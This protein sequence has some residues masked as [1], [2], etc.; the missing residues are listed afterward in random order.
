MQEI[1]PPLNFSTFYIYGIKDYTNLGQKRCINILLLGTTSDSFHYINTLD[2]SVCSN[3]AK[4]KK[5][6]SNY[7]RINILQYRIEELSS[8]IHKVGIH[9]YSL[10]ARALAILVQNSSLSHASK[11][12]LLDIYTSYEP[13]LF[14]T[15]VF[16]KSIE[17][18]NVYD[19]K[20]FE[21]FDLRELILNNP[22]SSFNDINNMG[23][24]H[25]NSHDSITYI[26]HTI[27]QLPFDY[28][29]LIQLLKPGESG[30]YLDT[31]N[32]NSF[33]KSNNIDPESHT[34]SEGTLELW[35]MKGSID[36]LA[37]IL[38]D[39]QFLHTTTLTYIL[40]GMITIR[41]TQI[42]QNALFSQKDYHSMKILNSLIADKKKEIPELIII[43]YTKYEQ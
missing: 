9:D 7:I 1:N 23:T 39:I 6:I 4:G 28:D 20:D 21:I 33:I 17:A 8:R 26:S 22:T 35:T 40:S 37:G 12:E 16:R 2:D 36:N 30:F 41:D 19:L 31:F 5:D 32:I 42:I 24:D 34:I 11:K 15:H 14:I 27:I 43:T 25:N 18:D 3:Y 29:N 13:L 38:R 10:S